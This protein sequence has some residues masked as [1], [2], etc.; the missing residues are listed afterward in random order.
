MLDRR[1]ERAVRMVGR[2]TQGDAR[3]PL[4]V[5]LAAQGVDERRFADARLAADEDDLAVAL[6]LGLLP[7]PAQETDLLVTADE[8]EIRGRG[9]KLSL[10]LL[11]Q[12]RDA[13]DLDR[14]GDAFERMCAETLAG[15]DV[16][17]EIARGG[18]DQDG[19]GAGEGLQAGGEVGRF[20]DDGL[21]ARGT[22]ADC[23]ADDDES[24][25][26]TNARGEAG[27][28][29]ARDPG[30]ERRQRVEDC[31]ARADAVAHELGDEAVEAPNGLAHGLLIGADH[32][33]HVLG[34]DL[35]RE[36]RRIRQVAEHHGQV[37]PLGA[38]QVAIGGKG[39]R[40]L[41]KP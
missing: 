13:P 20:A 30:A 38:R 31:E 33:A 1:I 24:A 14:L 27:P 41:R 29:A 3:Q 2:A 18:A 5:H 21:L 4:G 19:V 39:R 7:G 25:R 40:P 17:E 36:A 35:R 15:E 8:G 28:V 22:F 10:F 9:F 37:A 12:A 16:A 23:L 26:D 32:I 34:I 6:L 11:A